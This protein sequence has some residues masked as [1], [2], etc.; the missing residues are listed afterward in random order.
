MRNKFL[1]FACLFLF[2][3]LN[4]LGCGKSSSPKKVVN[5]FIEGTLSNDARIVWETSSY[6]F[7]DDTLLVEE[8]EKKFDKFK[9]DF[10]EKKLKAFK[11]FLKKSKSEIFAIKNIDDKKT[12]VFVEI[13]YDNKNP[14]KVNKHKTALKVK[15]K[16]VVINA[17]QG[18]YYIDDLYEESIIIYNQSE[19]NEKQ[20][21]SINHIAN[22]DPIEAHQQ[23]LNIFKKDKEYFSNLGDKCKIIFQKAISKEETIS[24]SNNISSIASIYEN[25]KNSYGE[26]YHEAYTE[27]TYYGDTAVSKKRG[28]YTSRYNDGVDVEG[29]INNKLK[30]H[31]I[32]VKVRYDFSTNPY[33]ETGVCKVATPGNKFT[34]VIDIKD[35]PPGKA[36]KFYKWV[37]TM[38]DGKF[39]GFCLNIFGVKPERRTSFKKG[40]ISIVSIYDIHQ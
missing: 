36:K 20:I 26:K 14:Y 21:A 9:N 1:L 17:K 32:S 8:K 11:F 24:K 10:R 7:W 2:S 23:C 37:D 4:L 35:I 33:S 34:G 39:V 12:H 40:S 15:A 31:H 5:S 25:I 6:D 38:T 18:G 3:F 28:G 27:T 29:A 19:D 22:S 30:Y 13:Q 16:F